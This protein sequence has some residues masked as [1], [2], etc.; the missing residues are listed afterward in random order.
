MIYIRWKRGSNWSSLLVRV[1][2][3]AKTTGCATH[4]SAINLHWRIYDCSTACWR[5]YKG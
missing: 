2:T 4:P 5:L 1:C 3:H